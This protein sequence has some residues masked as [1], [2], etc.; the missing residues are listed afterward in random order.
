MPK[1]AMPTFAAKQ[2]CAALRVSHG[3]LNSWA[4]AGYFRQFDAAVTTPG[5]ARKFS[6]EDLLRLF[7]QTQFLDR[8]ISAR[9]AWSLSE[10]CVDYI[11]RFSPTQIKIVSYTDG[12]E[13]ILL[14]NQE[15]GPGAI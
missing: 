8:D 5:K 4:H 13:E 10:L 15:P 3:T 9:T 1:A 11:E 7:I 14:D 2:V 12:R 6:F